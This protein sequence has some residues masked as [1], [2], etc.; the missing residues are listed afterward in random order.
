MSSPAPFVDGFADQRVADVGEEARLAL[1]GAAGDVDGAQPQLVGFVDP[2]H[3]L[4]VL[5]DRQV[6][7]AGRR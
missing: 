1:F 5:G 2:L 7:G 4:L 6:F 3:G